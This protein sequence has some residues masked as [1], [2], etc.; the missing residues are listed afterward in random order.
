MAEQVWLETTVSPGQFPDEYA[1]SGQQ[2]DGRTF[3]LFAS[4]D[5]VREAWPGAGQGRV[6]VDVIDRREDLCLVRLP[7]QTIE[8]GQHVTVRASQLE[9]SPPAREVGVW[10]EEDRC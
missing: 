9:H 10:S 1:V 7:A 2:Y 3:S 5:T 6:L 4:A 8:N